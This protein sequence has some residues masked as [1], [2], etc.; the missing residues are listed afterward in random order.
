[1]VIY[2]LILIGGLVLLTGSALFALRWALRTGQLKHPAKTALQI[3]D[4]E[5]PVGEMT[6]LFPGHARP[7][8]RDKEKW[9]RY[10]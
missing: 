2:Y 9:P 8:R 6:D 3:F 1:M 4:E 10:E 5:E 7:N